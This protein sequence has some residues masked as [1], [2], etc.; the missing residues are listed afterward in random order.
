MEHLLCE[1]LGGPSGLANNKALVTV[2]S[3]DF[4]HGLSMFCLSLGKCDSECEI[5]AES[6]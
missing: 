3:T 5:V 6:L 4:V 2:K 1:T